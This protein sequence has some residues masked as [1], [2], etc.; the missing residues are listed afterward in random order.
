M[1]GTLLSARRIHQV[2]RRDRRIRCRRR[3]LNAF[4]HTDRGHALSESLFPLQ[5][6]FNRSIRI[7]SR[8]DRLSSD[9]GALLQR[10]ADEMVGVSRWLSAH[11]E[12]P[13]DP[14]MV[15]HPQQELLRQMQY[16][17][18]QG[19]VDQDDATALRDDPVFRVAVSG[20][21]G[22]SPLESQPGRPDG[23]AS[24]PTLSREVETLSTV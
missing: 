21:R 4:F 8:A 11:L 1:D 15:V 18:G 12:D 9:A 19:W 23:L 5:P 20:R 10:E 13:R 24:Q 3:L 14:S 7:E 22:T 6:K 16:R 2:E 17:Q